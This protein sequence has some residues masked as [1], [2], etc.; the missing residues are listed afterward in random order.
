MRKLPQKV[1]MASS[2]AGKL[3]EIADI[4]ADLDIDIV[5][6]SEFDVADAEENGSTFAEN[7]LIKARH[8]SRTTG[9][10]AIADDSGLAVDAL[11][12]A[13]GVHSARYSG[14]EA[15]DERNIDKLLAA[16]DGIP[17]ERRGAAF[18]CVACYV[19][20][21]DA[22]PVIAAGQW[23]GRILHERRGDGG[24]GYDPVFFDPDL[25]CSSAELRPGQKNA[26]SHR[27]KALR[28]L[29]RKLREQEWR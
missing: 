21:D 4:L 11:D 26:R 27:G 1:V 14:T 29:A 19:A 12:G 15:S 8:A 22:E 9:L 18:H 25:G 5:P 13:P 16:L 24:F 7:A 17:D 20:S 28:E 10:P 2:N 3:R 23:R 6:Q